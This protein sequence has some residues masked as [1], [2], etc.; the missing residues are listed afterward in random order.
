MIFTDD[1]LKRLKDEFGRD[2]NG[3]LELSTKEFKSIIARLEAAEK[4]L[5]SFRHSDNISSELTYQRWRKVA[6][7]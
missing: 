3:G 1:Y 4:A 6:G 2:P 5:L 7:K